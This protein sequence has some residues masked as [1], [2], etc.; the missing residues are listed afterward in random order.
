MKFRE[1]VNP[2]GKVP[3]VCDDKL[4]LDP[5]LIDVT[6][7]RN[8]DKAADT[9]REDVTPLGKVP[10]VCDDEISLDPDLIDVTGCRNVDE[11]ADSLLSVTVKLIFTRVVTFQ[12]GTVI[13]VESTVGV[14]L[15]NNRVGLNV[16]VV[17]IDSFVPLGISLCCSV[18]GLCEAI[19]VL[20]LAGLVISGN[21]LDES[22]GFTGDGNN[23][24][25]CVDSYD[26]LV[27]VNKDVFRGV[28]G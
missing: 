11:V 18:A 25:G 22:D 8:V 9:F 17:L 1:D 28:T 10:E 21:R 27:C 15:S 20:G 7:C 23:I 19:V 4:S 6:G 24:V 26:L 5:E 16:V 13:V 3:E 2:S 12:L 14:V